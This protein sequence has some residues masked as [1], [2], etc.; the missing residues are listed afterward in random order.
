MIAVTR[1]IARSP[2][3]WRTDHS[4]YPCR[5]ILPA[6]EARRVGVECSRETPTPDL[7]VPVDASERWPQTR[8]S[9]RSRRWPRTSHSSRLAL[10]CAPQPR[11]SQPITLT[12]GDNVLL[13]LPGDLTGPLRPALW[14]LLGAVGCVPLVACTNVANL[15]LARQTARAREVALRISL[16]APR[17]RLV[18]HALSEAT[19]IALVGGGCGIVLAS[20]LV[21]ALRWLEPAICP[22]STPSAWTCRSCSLRWASQWSPRSFLR[23]HLHGASCSR[24]AQHPGAETSLAPRA[25][26]Q[27]YAFGS[28]VAELAIPLVLLVG[29]TLLTRSFVRLMEPTSASRGTTS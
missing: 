27:A 3:G 19:L 18:V 24:R 5:S 20:W 17:H 28:L 12:G 10:T 25:E 15:L 13:S 21:A 8:H 4:A 23:P 14:L 7:W 9:G 16:G 11:P 1:P 22:A 2:G 6:I 26:G 29:A